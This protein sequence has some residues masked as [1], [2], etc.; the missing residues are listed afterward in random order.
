MSKTNQK[1]PPKKWNEMTPKEKKRVKINL[2]C[3][4]IITCC[5]IVVGIVTCDDSSNENNKVKTSKEIVYNSKWDG[6]VKQVEDYLNNTLNDPDSYESVEW[7][8]V[9]KESSA[10]QR[11]VVRHKY[12]AKN[13]FGGV[14][15]KDQLFTLD[16]LGVI[17]NIQDLN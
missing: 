6:S 5:F 10:G 9:V 7:S 12:R 1:Q 16:S 4:G 2:L 3:L 14:I 13:G 17:I 8:P 15:L 11:F